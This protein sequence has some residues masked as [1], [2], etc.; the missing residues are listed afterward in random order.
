MGVTVEEL[1]ARLEKV[2][3]ELRER[4][5]RIHKLETRVRAHEAAEAM[6]PIKKGM[7]QSQFRWLKDVVGKYYAAKEVIHACPGEVL[8]PHEAPAQNK[9]GG[10]AQEEWQIFIV[11]VE[12]AVAG[13][14]PEAAR[15]MIYMRLFGGQSAPYALQR[16][17]EKGIR[18]SKSKAQ[19]LFERAVEDMYLALMDYRK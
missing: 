19:T 6:L 13:L 12:N 17:W 18:M 7:F 14:R 4:D 9:P 8:R 16:L 10:G 3:G 1:A 5:E 2:E 15:E 11:D